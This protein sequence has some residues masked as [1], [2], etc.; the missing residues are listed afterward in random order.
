[1]ELQRM[2]SCYFVIVHDGQQ[3]ATVDLQ[4]R[5]NPI[6]S[7]KSLPFWQLKEIVNLIQNYLNNP[8]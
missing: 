6:I 3:L 5:D 7:T 2:G 4:N 8:W 1:M